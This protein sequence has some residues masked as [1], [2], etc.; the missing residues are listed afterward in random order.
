MQKVLVI[1]YYWP[2]AG[3]P[4]VQRWLK[5]VKYLKDF[6]IEPVVYV[7]ENP[8]YPI[9]DDHLAHE[10]PKDIQ[11][12]K[13]PIVEPYKWASMLSKKKTKTISSG[14]IQEKEP[15]FVEKLLLWIRGNLFIPDARKLWVKPSITYLSEVI[16]EQGIQTIVTTGPPHSVH[17]IGMGLKKQ[18]QIEWIADFRDP[19]TTIGYHSKLRLTKASQRKHKELEYIV[20]NT[21]D[22]IIVTSNTTKQEFEKITA[23]PIRVITNGFD[24]NLGEIQMDG[25][26]TISHI[27]SLLTRRNPKSLWKA[28]Q[29][30]TAENE[31]FKKQLRI[32]FAGVV[33][34][35]VLQSVKACGLENCVVQL[36]YLP[37]N[38]ILEVQRK[39][40]LL[41]LLEIDSE[42]TKGIIPG[43][44]FEY[45]NAK[46]PIL[47]IGPREWEG[48]TIISETNSGAVFTPGDSAALK[49]VLLDWFELYQKG[50]LVVNSTG[51]EKYHR[52]ELTRALANYIQWESS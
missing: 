40:Q 32:Q 31:A 35:E 22:K 11:I 38:Q 26:F 48:G 25:L 34:E 33:G 18:H 46:R 7:P 9:V 6:G 52:R 30:L 27:G 16:E 50:A 51:I 5:F 45:L 29:E 39:S 21:S 3:G 20:L 13:Q 37:H 4:G 47:A 49:N 44:L 43:K 19:W 42:E 24:D 14:V 15:S 8:N 10:I 41:L 1:A 23:K 12:L 36:G 2:P 28:L 17:L